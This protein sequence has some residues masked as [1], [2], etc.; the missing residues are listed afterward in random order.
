[1]F[2]DHVADHYKRIHSKKK[3]NRWT[4]NLILQLWDMQW[5][6]WDHRNNIE[7]NEM[8]PAKQQKY[9]TLLARARDELQEGCA[10]LLPSDRH[11]FT[12]ETNMLSLSLTNLEQWLSDVKL[13][14][15]TVDDVRIRKQEEVA[16]SRA[17]MHAWL[18]TH[19]PPD[20]EIHPATT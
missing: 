9:D 2:A 20:Q 8:T 10:D 3:H 11:Y 19:T 6:L 5:R 7:H 16:R 12:D 14:R 18:Q 4:Q 13:A 15:R 17:T 1:M